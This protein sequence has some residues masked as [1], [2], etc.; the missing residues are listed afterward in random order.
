MAR[1]HWT[2][3]EMFSTDT[4]R[5]DVSL[6]KIFVDLFATFIKT[7]NLLKIRVYE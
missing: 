6:S 4:S 2:S 3:S 7:R 1:S 5:L